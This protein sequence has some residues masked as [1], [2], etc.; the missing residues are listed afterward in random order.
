[1]NTNDEFESS[2]RGSIK[3]ESERR[4]GAYL[5]SCLSPTN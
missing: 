4:R 5:L 1:M 2:C 3:I